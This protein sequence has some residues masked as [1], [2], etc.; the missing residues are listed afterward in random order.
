MRVLPLSLDFRISYKTCF[1]QWDLSRCDTKLAFAVGPSLLYFCH[2]RNKDMPWVGRWMRHTAQKTLSLSGRSGASPNTAVKAEGLSHTPLRSVNS[3][4]TRDA[5]TSPAEIERR[6]AD[7]HMQELNNCF[8]LYAMEIFLC[9]CLLHSNSWL[10]HSAHFSSPKNIQGISSRR[11]VNSWTV[12]D[13][14]ETKVGEHFSLLMEGRS[15]QCWEQL[16]KR[17]SSG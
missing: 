16:W 14:D 11:L 4:P 6:I 8:L 1:G 2:C 12:V 9:A 13:T 15:G 17:Q 7:L 10:I 3:Q 5:W